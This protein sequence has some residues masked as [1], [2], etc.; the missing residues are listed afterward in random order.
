MLSLALVLVVLGSQSF[1]KAGFKNPPATDTTQ[2]YTV[3]GKSAAI[4]SVMIR[5]SKKKGNVLYIAVGNKKLNT[6]DNNVTG[7]GLA[8]KSESREARSATAP[9]FDQIEV[10]NGGYDEIKVDKVSTTQNIY[11]IEKIN[12]PLRL[13]LHSGNDFVEFELKDA[14]RWDINVNYKNN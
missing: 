10:L 7:I 9:I 11:T 2:T 6:T 3:F 8:G 5:K 14:G 1:A 4:E 12:F 13:K